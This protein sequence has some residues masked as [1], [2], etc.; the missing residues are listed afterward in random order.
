MAS[1]YEWE[2]PWGEVQVPPGDLGNLQRFD[3]IVIPLSCVHQLSF[4]TKSR[5][6]FSISVPVLCEAVRRT[7]VGQACDSGTSLHNCHIR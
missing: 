2:V 6:P 1:G 5:S 7:H 4:K 3:E